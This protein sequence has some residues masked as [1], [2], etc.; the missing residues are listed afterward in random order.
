M[1]IGMGTF[2]FVSQL[3]NNPDVK[4]ESSHSKSDLSFSG[5][6]KDVAGLD[7]IFGDD[8]NHSD[9]LKLSE[10][11]IVLSQHELL[12]LLERSSKKARTDRLDTIQEMLVEFVAQVSPK[13]AITKIA[14]FSEHRRHSLLQVIFSHWS[15]ANFD[16]ALA[17][18]TELPR[19]DRRIAANAIFVERSNTSSLDITTKA[20]KLNVKSELVAI[21]Q[22]LEIYEMLDQD[23][24][25]AFNTLINDEIDDWE[26][27]DIYRQVAEKWFQT[28]GISIV[29]LIDDARLRGGV[30]GELFEQITQVDREA[31]LTFISG[32]DEDTRAR[33]GYR[34]LEDWVV[35]DAEVALNAVKNLPKSFFR[36]SLLRSVATDWARESPNLVMDQLLEIPR[37]YRADALSVIATKFAKEDPGYALERIEE[38]RSVPGTDVDRS[39]ESIIRTWSSDAPKLALDWVLTHAKEDANKRIELLREVL[40]EYVLVQPEH[41]MTV[42]VEEFSVDHPYLS[43]Q[44][45]VV[46][47]LLYAERFDEAITLLGQ[48]QGEGEHIYRY[49]GLEL[50]KHDR[51]DDVLPL[52]DSIVEGKKAEFF[53]SLAS[54]ALIYEHA[55]D[56]IEMIAGLPTT[57][58]Q[59]EVAE[60]LLSRSGVAQEFTKEQLETLK[61]F[62]SE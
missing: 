31:A 24:S 11:L 36:H 10:S 54:S 23:P 32:V 6:D 52:A 51:L 62:V 56:V 49:V 55:S 37:L 28:H 16:E 42:A 15:L 14:N 40:P 59:L 45:L 57:N 7:W 22:E 44:A 8:L 4:V 17:A 47:S 29:L 3:F 25:G 2:L 9:L 5:A 48:V 12:E 27:I 21:K 35:A 43:L 38:L 34:L 1:A 13:E 30:F 33:L 53:Y 41:A 39:V 46:N 60:K 58:L 20:N 19:S 18:L 26:Q 61:S 50:L